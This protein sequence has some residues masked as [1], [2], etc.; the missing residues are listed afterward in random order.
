MKKPALM[1]RLGLFV[2]NLN[3]F[4]DPNT[5]DFTN[6]APMRA[7][8]NVLSIRTTLAPP[9]AQFDDGTLPVNA[10]DLVFAERTSCSGDGTLTGF[11]DD[12]CASNERELTGSLRDFTIGAMVQHFPLTLE[13]SASSSDTSG[14][15]RQPDFRF[16]TEDEL[17]ALEAFMLSISHQEENQSLDTVRLYSPVAER[18]RLNFVGF[19]VFDAEPADGRPA[20][21]CNACHFNGG[22]NIDPTFPFS[23]S[24]RPNHDLADIAA[25]SG[26]ILSHNRSF[27]P[28]VERLA[29]QAGDIIVQSI[30][31]PSIAHNCFNEA[32]GEVPLLPGDQPGIPSAGCNQSLQRTTGVRS[33][34]QPTV[35]PRTS[36]Q[37]D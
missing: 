8:N 33:P 27:G 24:V 16:A 18:G 37:Y 11:R 12:F 19:N 3:G 13:R 22:A 34:G 20:L 5:Q 26:S 15:A 1:R 21:N 9:P 14:Y 32:L 17:D 10:D 30:D 28:Q 2:E 35:L 7:P 4:I 23:P 31:D 25:S 6:R 36:N 29:D